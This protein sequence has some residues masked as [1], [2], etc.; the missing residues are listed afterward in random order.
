MIEPLYLARNAP[1][2][3]GTARTPL[4]FRIHVSSLALL[5]R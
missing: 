2:T 3:A 1:T 5:K 4:K